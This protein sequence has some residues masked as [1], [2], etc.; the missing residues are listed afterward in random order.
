MT[1]RQIAREFGLSRKT[2]RRFLEATAFP[3][4][5]PRRRSSALEPY[6]EYLQKRWAEGCHNAARLWRELQEQGYNG[7]RS[8]VKE[9]LQ[10]WRSQP[11]PSTARSRKLPGLSRI[12][13]WLAKPMAERLE[14]EQ[15]WIQI[16]T[17]QH[18]EVATAESLAQQF[19]EIVREHKASSL[20]AWL[21]SAETSGIAELNG[22]AAGI[23]RDHVAVLAGIQQPWS[24]GQVEGQ[25]HRLKLLKRQMYG[26]SGFQ[27]LLRRV[28]PF[29]PAHPSRSP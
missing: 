4:Q 23:R 21:E 12:A 11:L 29:L 27:L 2:V 14:A 3:E 24:N 25:I 26:R 20:N 7:Q 10:P 16:I 6:Q 17:Q 1:Q 15:Q 13:F 19:R 28:L 9:F 8:R 22:F 5:A 18:H